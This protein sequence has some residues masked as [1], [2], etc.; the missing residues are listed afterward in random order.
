M[1]AAKYGKTECVQFLLSA[2]ADSNIQDKVS[3]ILFFCSVVRIIMCESLDNL[4]VVVIL[5]FF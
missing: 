1:R 5:F 4:I 2:G 3:N